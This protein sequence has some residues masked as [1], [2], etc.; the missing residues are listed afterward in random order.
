MNL[1]HGKTVT[2][3]IGELNLSTIFDYKHN[4][5]AIEFQLSPQ[6]MHSWAR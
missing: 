2:I 4:G 5:I 1:K 6:V 3:Q